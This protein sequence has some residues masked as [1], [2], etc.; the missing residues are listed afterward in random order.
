MPNHGDTQADRNDMETNANLS[1][2]VP[3]PIDF[4]RFREQRYTTT[5]ARAMKS[6]GDLL[7]KLSKRGQDRAALDGPMNEWLTE[8]RIRV[9]PEN[10]KED[11]YDWC[12]LRNKRWLNIIESAWEDLHSFTYTEK[13]LEPAAGI[14]EQDTM[15]KALQYTREIIKGME[16]CTWKSVLLRTVNQLVAASEHSDKVTAA[17]REHYLAAQDKN[18]ALGHNNSKSAKT[19]SRAMDQTRKVQRDLS[20]LR[21]DLQRVKKNLKESRSTSSN[22]KRARLKDD[23]GPSR[24]CTFNDTQLETLRT[25]FRNIPFRDKKVWEAAMNVAELATTPAQFMEIKGMFKRSRSPV[26]SASDEE[27]E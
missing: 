6:A 26:Y 13:R 2:S 7:D 23:V 12:S 18:M 8:A 20:S 1:P 17:L 24:P 25:L 9:M 15:K 14:A 10:V 3:Y 21:P 4:W 11:L 5:R 16:K 19:L 27:E 22:A